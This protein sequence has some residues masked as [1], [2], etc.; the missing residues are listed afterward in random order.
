MEIQRIYLGVGS[1]GTSDVLNTVS[2]ITSLLSNWYQTN[3]TAYNLPP[4]SDPTNQITALANVLAGWQPYITPTVQPADIIAFLTPLASQALSQATQ[5]Q[6]LTLNQQAAQFVL[7]TYNQNNQIPATIASTL[8]W[9]NIPWSTINK[10]LPAFNQVTV[11]PVIVNPGDFFTYLGQIPGVSS[12]MNIPVNSGGM[13]QIPMQSITGSNNATLP[14][15]TNS[16]KNLGL[17]DGGL[18]GTLD[19]STLPGIVQGVDS[20][21]LAQIPWNRIGTPDWNAVS[22]AI[23]QYG[24]PTAVEIQTTVACWQKCVLAGSGNVTVDDFFNDAINGNQQNGCCR[25]TCANDSTTCTQAPT[26]QCD[27]NTPCQTGYNCVNGACVQS[28]PTPPCSST[29]PCPTGYDCINGVCVQSTPTPPCSSTA[30]CPTGY[31][32]INGVCV[33][34]TAQP[35]PLPTGYVCPSGSNWNANTGHCI[36]GKGNIVQAVQAPAVPPKDNTT[37]YV[38]AGLV[39]VLIIGGTIIAISGKGKSAEKSTST[40][41]ISNV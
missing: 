39:G 40:P 24:V 19:P 2:S 33:Q 31:D 37:L 26:P 30:P 3:A 28:T 13:I 34:H 25:G 9:G 12:S 6:I 41:A 17:S 8:P 4:M 35:I 22:A 36:D 1:N 5:T 10:W 23:T 20:S 16:L 29:A 21:I 11:P 7:A 14:I 15:N 18:T 38:I 27:V 32:C